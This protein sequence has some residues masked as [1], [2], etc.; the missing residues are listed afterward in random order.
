LLFAF[1]TA[2]WVII[3]SNWKTLQLVNCFTAFM[4]LQFYVFKTLCFYSKIS[5]LKPNLFFILTTFFTTCPKTLMQIKRLI[6][7]VNDVWQYLA[8][9]G[10]V[11]HSVVV[12]S[13]RKERFTL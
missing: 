3:F 7:P 4:L 5:V 10:S 8:F 6:Y 12:Q 2:W 9:K 13:F 11:W 1:I